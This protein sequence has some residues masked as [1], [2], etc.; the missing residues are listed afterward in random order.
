MHNR[1]YIRKLESVSVAS[2]NKSVFD[3][4]GMQLNILQIVPLLY[5]FL[6]S[7]Q[8]DSSAM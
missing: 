8:S 6:P 2:P 3:D 1:T 7:K 5:V 4:P